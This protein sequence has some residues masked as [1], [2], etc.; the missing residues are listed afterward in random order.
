[1]VPPY[2][3]AGGCVVVVVVVPV[4]GPGPEVVTVVG[5]VV[6]VPDGVEVAVVV[7]PPQ[8]LKTRMPARIITRDKNI[9]FFIPIMLLLP[10][11]IKQPIA[12]L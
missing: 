4:V 11:D 7:V 1:M 9:N 3:P 8:P 6:V 10:D 2:W 12:I 5:V